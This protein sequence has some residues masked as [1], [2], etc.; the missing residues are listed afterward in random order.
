ML[1]A[2]FLD[3]YVDL[4]ASHFR[5]RSRQAWFEAAESLHLTFALVQTVDELLA[6]PQLGSRGFVETLAEHPAGT[7]VMPAP[8]MQGETTL[9]PPRYVEP[10]AD[11]QDVMDRWLTAN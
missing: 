7:V 9:Q 4:M 5:T 8:V 10:G 1:V 3:E 11:T 6:C 2:A